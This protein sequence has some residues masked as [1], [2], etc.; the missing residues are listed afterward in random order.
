MLNLRAQTGCQ[1]YFFVEGP[2]FPKKSRR[3]ARIPYKNILSAMTN[4]MIRD[5]IHIVQTANEMHTAQRLLDF[6]HALGKIEI[7]YKHPRESS[8][9]LAAALGGDQTTK[10]TKTTKTTNQ[11]SDIPIAVTGL[12]EKSDALLVVEIWARLAGVSAVTAKTLVTI[13]SVKDF[14]TGGVSNEAIKALR[15][16]AN[17]QLP[18]KAAASLRNLSQGSNREG[19]KILSGVPGISPAMATQLLTR[20]SGGLSAFVTYNPAAMAICTIKQKGRTVKLGQTRAN[21]IARLFDFIEVE[22][23]VEKA[24][25]DEELDDEELDALLAEL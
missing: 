14:V 19:I 24:P 13:F 3:F 9:A 7:P 1:L 20:R 16:P 12:I 17:R 6:T 18:K 4:L 10:T 15:T 22:E 21:R 11:N 5:G 25:C 2:A 8:E 23:A